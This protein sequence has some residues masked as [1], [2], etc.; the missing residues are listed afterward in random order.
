MAHSNA[1]RPERMSTLAWYGQLLAVV[2]VVAIIAAI[3]FPV[4]AKSRTFSGRLD[5]SNL[6]QLG[7][8]RQM[9][10]AENDESLPF[11]GDYRGG[12]LGR[13]GSPA[14][15]VAGRSEA[16]GSKSPPC[17]IPG[18]VDF[19]HLADAGSGSIFAYVKNDG[20]FKAVQRLETSG[21]H[22]LPP[23]AQMDP[24]RIRV[25]FSMNAALAPLI[26]ADGGIQPF[27]VL[28]LE[29]SAARI[30]LVLEDPNTAT[31]GRFN[32][33]EATPEFPASRFRLVRSDT[34]LGIV[35]YLDG[36]AKAVPAE[37]YRFGR[38]PWHEF[39]WNERL[40]ARELSSGQ[41]KGV[42]R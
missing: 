20:N 3:L 24:K 23:H 18:T 15:V 2:F 13:A 9:Y 30:A 19:C 25:S 31:G 27:S 12:A 22:E 28:E 8:G 5:I 36:R 17:E 29:D 10:A 39:G 7:T 11:P 32:P 41:Q 16:T 38:R 21:R 40:E 33:G 1:N 35:G 42:T 6:K 26:H 34:G 4:F 14:W 37:N